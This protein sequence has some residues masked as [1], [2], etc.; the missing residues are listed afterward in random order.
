M[1]KYR[2]MGARTKSRRKKNIPIPLS[3]DLPK[4]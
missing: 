2:E 3:T 4:H 1:A